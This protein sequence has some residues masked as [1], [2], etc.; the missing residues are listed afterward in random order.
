[1]ILHI[2]CTYKY[3][4]CQGRAEQQAGGQRAVCVCENDDPLVR[5]FDVDNKLLLPHINL[6]KCA[7]SPASARA[8]R[9]WMI[10]RVIARIHCMLGTRMR[11]IVYT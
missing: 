7:L 11:R 1:M 3:N 5:N 6:A 10:V 2:Y 4:W 8:R 9:A